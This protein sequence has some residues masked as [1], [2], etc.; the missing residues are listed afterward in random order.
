M[1]IF[2]FQFLERYKGLLARADLDDETFIINFAKAGLIIEASAKVYGIKVDNL[3]INL[4]HV[5]ESL[6]NKG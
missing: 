5:L 1:I 3:W 2:L 6:K 4:E